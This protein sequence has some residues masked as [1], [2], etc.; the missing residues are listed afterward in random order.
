MSTYGTL[1]FISHGKSVQ[2]YN[3]N[4]SRPH[5]YGIA[6]ATEL[7]YLLKQHGLPWLQNCINALQPIDGESAPPTA[8]D[9]SKLEPYT[10]LQIGTCNNWFTLLYGT[11]GSIQRIIDSGY[12]FKY[13]CTEDYNY[14]INLDKNTLSMEYKT[15]VKIYRFNQLDDCISAWSHPTVA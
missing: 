8:S 9:I 6:L 4:D 2:T 10:N 7:H 14:T 1:I 12:I 11:M 3:H 15:T 13:P 5:P